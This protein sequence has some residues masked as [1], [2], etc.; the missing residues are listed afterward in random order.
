[1]KK[2]TLETKSSN[3]NKNKAVIEKQ[4]GFA[5]EEDRFVIYH[6]GQY[7]ENELG[8]TLKFP[9]RETALNYIDDEEWELEE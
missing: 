1:M 9:D 2:K 7:L 4:Y 6:N 8:E 5:D 3:S